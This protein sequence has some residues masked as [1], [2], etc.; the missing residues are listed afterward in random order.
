MI[1]AF[2]QTKEYLDS[3][4]INSADLLDQTAYDLIK[5][6]DAYERASQALRRRFSR[7]AE[8][9]NGIDRGDRHS[10]IKREKEFFLK[11]IIVKKVF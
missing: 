9:V 2:P 11:I 8:Q 5:D 4:D 7:G 3:I 6:E 1:T 10:K